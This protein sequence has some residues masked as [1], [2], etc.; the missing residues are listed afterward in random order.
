MSRGKIISLRYM[1]SRSMCSCRLSIYSWVFIIFVLNCTLYY[2]TTICLVRIHFDLS[3]YWH[4][5]SRRSSS[6]YY[7]GFCSNKLFKAVRVGGPTETRNRPFLKVKFANKGIDA[8]NLSNIL[9]QKSCLNKIPQLTF[10]TRSRKELLPKFS[11]Q[12]KFAATRL[13]RSFP[14]SPILQLLWYTISVRS[15]WP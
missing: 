13:P 15:M 1:M 4:W 7:F 2:K 8:L 12:S 9:N 14:G 11:I 5:I 10:N 3:F 6:G